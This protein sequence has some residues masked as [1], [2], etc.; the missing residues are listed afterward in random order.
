MYRT[1]K[2]EEGAVV[3]A[4]GCK[5]LQGL[6]AT[7]ALSPACPIADGVYHVI[8]QLTPE[9]YEVI[10]VARIGALE[11][12]G[13]KMVMAIGD[14]EGHILERDSV[15]TTAPE[16]YVPPM[17]EWFRERNID[18]LGIGADRPRSL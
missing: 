1:L 12:G 6:E 9:I 2:Q 18:A 16:E 4:N 15:P 7:L 17:V 8:G 14:E 5:A 10:A 3:P 11:A 13:T